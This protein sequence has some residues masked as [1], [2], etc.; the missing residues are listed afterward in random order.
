MKISI[1]SCGWLGKPL[2]LHLQEAGYPV[3]GART[4]REGV[5]ELKALGLDACQVILSGEALTAPPAFW[6]TDILI[7]NIPPRMSRGGNAHIAEMALLRNLL[8]TAGIRKVLFISSTAVYRDVNGPVTEQ[9]EEMPDTANGQALRAVEKLLRT[10]PV[11]D[12][13]VLRFGGLIGYDRLPDERRILEGTRINSLPMNVIHRDDC[14]GVIRTVI[15]KDIWGEV[16]N[17]CAGGHPLRR[18]YYATAARVLGVP[19]PP[20]PPPDHRPYKIVDSGK[21]I[22]ALGYAFKYNDPLKVFEK[23]G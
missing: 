9:H 21:L 14:I 16:F 22:A 2:A 13:T 1:L 17:A 10:S 18:D 23:E 6:E 12:T 4:S 15:E 3:K 11:F 8:E 5:E 20:A 19:L 7:I